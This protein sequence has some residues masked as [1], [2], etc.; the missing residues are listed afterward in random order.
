MRTISLMHISTWCRGTALVCLW[1]LLRQHP[2]GSAHACL[3]CP[4]ACNSNKQRRT[5]A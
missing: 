1:Q 3:F 4:C 2:A 5:P